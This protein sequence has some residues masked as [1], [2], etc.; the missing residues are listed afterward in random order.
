MKDA[1]T[2][3]QRAIRESNEQDERVEQAAQAQARE[4][5]ELGQAP[6]IPKPNRRVQLVLELEYDPYNHLLESA[7]GLVNGMSY[8]RPACEVCKVSGEDLERVKM[9]YMCRVCVSLFVAAWAKRL[10]VHA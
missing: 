2:D 6:P 5:A 9:T 10:G 7:S 4:E 8:T 1:E 3:V